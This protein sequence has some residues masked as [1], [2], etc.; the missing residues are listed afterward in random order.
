MNEEAHQ[1]N[2]QGDD[3]DGYAL[4]ITMNLKQ[5]R[6]DESFE[7]KRPSNIHE[8]SERDQCD[9]RHINPTLHKCHSENEN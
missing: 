1:E 5:M 2:L 3:D 7:E 4:V 9:A 8:V 6:F